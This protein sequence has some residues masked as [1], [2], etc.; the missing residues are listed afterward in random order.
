MAARGPAGLRTVPA[1]LHHAD[2]HRAAARMAGARGD[3]IAR[4]SRVPRARPLLGVRGLA[5]GGATGRNDP[6]AERRL[7]LELVL[8]TVGCAA[9]CYTLGRY[10]RSL[11]LQRWEFVLN[12]PE[13]RALDA[14]RR[15]MELDSAP[16]PRPPGAAP[17]PPGR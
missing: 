10:N 15:R 4:F 1:G 8:S 5:A 17:Q 12:A 11:A 3:R 6:R 9:L 13:Q 7:M 14:L 16:A 2:Q